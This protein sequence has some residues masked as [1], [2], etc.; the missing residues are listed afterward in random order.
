[1]GQIAA[2][3]L[4]DGDPGTS[5]HVQLSGGHCLKEVHAS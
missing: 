4:S 5:T 3:Q 1:M 2:E